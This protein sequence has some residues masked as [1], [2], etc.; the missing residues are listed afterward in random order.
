MCGDQDVYASAALAFSAYSSSLNTMHTAANNLL[1]RSTAEQQ[2]LQQ[3]LKSSTKV[4]SACLR[5]RL[6]IHAL[7]ATATADG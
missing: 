1:N 4:A 7:T 2:Q 5:R 6:L 3:Q